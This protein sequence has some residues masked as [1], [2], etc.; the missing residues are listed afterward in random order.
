MSFIHILILLYP[1]STRVL[2][3]VTGCVYKD[4]KISISTTT[5]TFICQ[6][7]SV[8]L[9]SKP[10]SLNLIGWWYWVKNVRMEWGQSR[11][12]QRK[13][14]HPVYSLVWSVTHLVAGVTH[15]HS[16]SS[17]GEVPGERFRWRLLV[18]VRVLCPHP[19][20]RQWNTSKISTQ[21]IW[22]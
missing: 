22:W 13:T 10:K 7:L 6:I 1:T 8:S 17:H 9:W 4:D 20:T 14:E 16:V 5:G 12:C 19:A 18:R 15:T 11:G 3:A 21:T 2:A